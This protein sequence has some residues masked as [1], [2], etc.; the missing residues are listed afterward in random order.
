MLQFSSVYMEELPSLLDRAFGPK[1]FAINLYFSSCDKV[2]N[3][4]WI[5][6][7]MLETRSQRCL[8]QVDLGYQGSMTI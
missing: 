5:L 3:A 8:A 2:V 1:L 6:W 7:L 4:A